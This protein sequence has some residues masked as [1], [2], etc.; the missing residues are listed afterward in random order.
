MPDITIVLA[1]KNYSSWS[2]RGWL[3]LQLTGAEHDE[4]VIP[5]GQPDTKENIAPHSPSGKLPVLI[6][7]GVRVWD[8]FAIAEHL[9]ERFPEAGL[10]PAEPLARAVARSIAAEMHSSFTA[11]RSEL[12][13][14]MKG[15]G[16]YRDVRISDDAKS[17]VERVTGIWRACRR[18]FGRAG[19]F[20]FGAP[21]AADAFF[22]PVVSRFVTYAIPLDK[23]SAR[24]R[25]AVM[26]WEPM[27]RWAEAALAEPWQNDRY[28]R[29][30]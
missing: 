28:E 23:I 24:Y 20:L 4:E 12:P 11:M 9:N 25:D 22:A 5:L 8:S 15:A 13:M 1:N 6:D 26:A 2:L 10:W 21:S 14:N 29:R 18:D 17:D 27:V 3:L 7:N 30:P 16:R 19:D